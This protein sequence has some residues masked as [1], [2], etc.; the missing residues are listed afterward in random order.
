VRPAATDSM[1]GGPA[2]N[3]WASDS[4][5]R[6]CRSPCLI[7]TV[8][9]AL[10]HD[11]GGW[12]AMATGHHPL[13]LS[14]STDVV[15]TRSYGVGHPHS[16]N[17]Y[18]AEAT[19][20][21]NSSVIA[22]IPARSLPSITIDPLHARMLSSFDRRRRAGLRIRSAQIVETDAVVPEDLV[23]GLVGDRQFQEL[24]GRVRVVR[25]PVWVVG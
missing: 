22:S 9:R 14:Q 23:L 3:H 11:H 2:R 10:A 13:A 7:M 19:P 16:V 20:T 25:V 12:E 8:V 4:I 6:C 5:P 17:G 1:M 15:A 18:C 24:F 21:V